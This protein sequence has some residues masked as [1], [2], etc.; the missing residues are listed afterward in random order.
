MGARPGTRSALSR[1]SGGA[2]AWHLGENWGSG[3]QGEM[4]T[5]LGKM[6]TLANGRLAPQ[7]LSL[8]NRTRS[9]VGERKPDH[10]PDYAL[11][12]PSP[13]SAGADEAARSRASSGFPV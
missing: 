8:R 4:V 3:A 10:K 11:R 2:H 9:H 5:T 7:S 13:S 6:D 12:V 1:Y